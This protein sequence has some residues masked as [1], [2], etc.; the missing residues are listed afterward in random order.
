MRASRIAFL[1]KKIQE[2]G[3]SITA[4]EKTFDECLEATLPLLDPQMQSFKS[5]Y[6]DNPGYWNNRRAV[7]TDI[8]TLNDSVVNIS[9][10][11]KIESI[12]GRN[13]ASPFVTISYQS[14]RFGE[15]K[16]LIELEPLSDDV[17]IF[18]V[19]AANRFLRENKRRRAWKLSGGPK[20]SKRTVDIVLGSLVIPVWGLLHGGTS[21][22]ESNLENISRLMATL[23]KRVDGELNPSV[24]EA[25]R[26]LLD[27]EINEILFDLYKMNSEER[28]LVSDSSVA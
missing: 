26:D 24:L 16:E 19:L 6:Y 8:L 15:W 23:R 20:A 2:T 13:S 17:R 28:R 18:L 25:N 4:L 3:D 21:R 1:A 22:T 7:P 27:I 14:E 10:K 12:D 11:N 5:D 9:V